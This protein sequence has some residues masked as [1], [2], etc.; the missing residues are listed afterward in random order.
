M[1]FTPTT[2]YD[3]QYGQYG[4]YGHDGHDGH[5]GQHLTPL[6]ILSGARQNSLTRTGVSL[7]HTVHIVYIV[8]HVHSY[9][10]NKYA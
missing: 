10:I 6:G 9:Y 2:K 8:H 5:D 1:A 3:G 4:Q 7:F